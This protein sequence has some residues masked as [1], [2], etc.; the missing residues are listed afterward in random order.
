MPGKEMERMK[1]LVSITSWRA[2]KREH[3][4]KVLAEYQ[5]FTDV[6]VSFALS[7]NY[8]F[9]VPSNAVV[10]PKVH[11]GYFHS[12]NNK[13]FLKEHYGDYTHI[14]ESDDDCLI[15][16]A[17]LDYYI[18]WQDVLPANQIPGFLSYELVNGEKKLITMPRLMPKRV[19]AYT[20]GF[21]PWNI[22]STCF[23]AD[24]ERFSKVA[25]M[26][27]P[28]QYMQYSYGDSSR[29]L[30]YGVFNK[31][32]CNEGVEN[33][34]ALVHHLPTKYGKRFWHDFITP[35]MLLT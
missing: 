11:D 8:A 3:L 30:I 12:W 9:N 6:E 26:V 32:V 34:A 31:V 35:A 14:L 25:D 2:E 33:E 19:H 27:E 23:I 1:L 4:E 7:V 28:V 13:P 22:H 16:R 20:Y 10:L 24:R 17:N 15:T 29:S 21:T 18:K 5:S